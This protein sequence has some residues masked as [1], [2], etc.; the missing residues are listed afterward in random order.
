MVVFSWHIFFG[1]GVFTAPSRNGYTR[2]LR[3]VSLRRRGLSK[4]YGEAV[5]DYI[6]EN[7]EPSDKIY[8]WGWVPG[9]YVKAQRF[10]SASRAFSMPR[11]TAAVLGQIVSDL[12]TEFKR[13][14]P[15]YI[16]DTRKRHIPVQRPP[17]ELWPIAYFR[18][19]GREEPVPDF[20]PPVDKQIAE[21]DEMHAKFL[22]KNFGEDEAERYKLLAPFRKF[23]MDNYR[24][25]ELSQY[26][27]VRLYGQLTLMHRGFDL[28]VLFE[29]KNPVLKD[30]A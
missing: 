2:T 26:Q 18:V 7:S 29:L 16:V 8:V 20:L 28:P 21:Y 9:I 27:P 12:L 15:K 11:P 14:M 19:P 22:R 17:Y 13:Q 3:A 30:P 6:R 10:S 23:V 24:I 5:G 25:V 4:N 1:T